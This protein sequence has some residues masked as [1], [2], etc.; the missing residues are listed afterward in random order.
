MEVLDEVLRHFVDLVR[1]SGHFF[2]EDTGPYEGVELVVRVFSAFAVDEEVEVQISSYGEHV[3]VKILDFLGF[4]EDVDVF[5]F[6]LGHSVVGVDEVLSELERVLVFGEVPQSLI[7]EPDM[8]VRDGVVD[9]EIVRDVHRVD[10]FPRVNVHEHSL[11]Q[12]GSL[13]ER[14]RMSTLKSSGVSE[15]GEHPSQFASL[16]NILMNIHALQGLIEIIRE[17]FGLC[18]SKVLLVVH[19]IVDLILVPVQIADS[20]SDLEPL[21]LL[22]S[23]IQLLVHLLSHVDSLNVELQRRQLIAKIERMS[24]V[25][26]LLLNRILLGLLQ[27]LRDRS[28]HNL[29]LTRSFKHVLFILLA[30]HRVNVL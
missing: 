28:I 11:Q 5:H 27:Q 25:R 22:L 21:T 16:L 1:V 29:L 19:P 15:I 3:V 6:L 13:Q 18:I 9:V 8:H 14:P 17:E 4:P 20:P 26:N 24:D 30:E 7:D 12:G 23:V 2:V 10:E